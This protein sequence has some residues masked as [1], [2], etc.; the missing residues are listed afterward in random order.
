MPRVRILPQP[1][2]QPVPGDPLHPGPGPDAGRHLAVSRSMASRS[3]TT[4]AARPSPTTP[5]CPRSRWPRSIPDAPFDKI[6]YIGCGVTTG[7]GAVINTAKVE[8]GARRGVRSRR[9]RPQR[10]PGPAAGRRRH[11]RRRR[12]QPGEEGMGRAFGMTHF[13]NPSE[14][15][16]RPRAHLVDLTK[17]GADYTFDARQ[18]Q[19]D[20][21][22]ARMRA[23]GL[24]RI[25]HHRRRRR[26]SGNL[27]PP[28]P[29]GHRPVLARHRLRR[30]AR[31]HRRA[32][33][34]RLVHGRAR[35]KSTR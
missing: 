25:D 35:S 13:V 9:H 29:A 24:G 18:R 22:G 11:D 26:R 23:Q 27:H 30:R 8:I 15:G 16:R 31:P 7:I 2:D 34:R 10:D 20:A 5:C 32:E 21:P 6:C 1:E 14:G 17:G 4:W 12:P 19:G 28:V 3:C 33:D